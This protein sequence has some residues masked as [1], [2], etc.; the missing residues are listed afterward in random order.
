[1]KFGLQLHQ[2]RGIEALFAEA[3]LADEQGFDS[4][5]LFDHLMDIGGR[6]TRE[7][8]QDSFTLMTALG[9]VTRRT[10][11][12]WAMLN[13]G[14]RP[15]AL[16]AK[17]L[18]T[19]DQ[20]TNGRVIC[21][22]G[23]GWFEPEYRAYDIPLIED[24]DARV[25]YAREVVQLFKELW[26]HPAPERTTFEGQFVRVHDLPFNPAPVQQ[27][28]PPIW[29]GGDS[30]ETIETV[31]RFADGW[32]MLRSGNPETLKTVMSKDDW[33]KRE[34][35]LVKNGRLYVGSSPD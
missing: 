3:R 21:T 28:H 11:L 4:I 31:K 26:T 15:P 30:E 1:M 32:V 24:H 20:I 25:A 13:L 12:A 6:D 17:M 33:P 22:V 18:A 16:M 29:F 8:P 14:F 27:P 10:R 9:A 23:A 35:T 7:N 5:W 19:L 2:E 34:M